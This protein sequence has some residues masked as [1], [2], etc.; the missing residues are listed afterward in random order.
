[1]TKKSEAFTLN[2]RV[3]LKHG[4]HPS[5]CPHTNLRKGILSILDNVCKGL[6]ERRQAIKQCPYAIS[7]LDRAQA[8][9]LRP[10]KV[11]SDHEGHTTVLWAALGLEP[12]HTRWSKL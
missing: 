9:K 12:N 3:T 5:L 2:I 11:K 10:D 4:G 7:E 8:R 6:V 1:M